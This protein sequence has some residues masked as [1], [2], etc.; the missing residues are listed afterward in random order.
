MS[1][2]RAHPRRTIFRGGGATTTPRSLWRSVYAVR[3]TLRAS[4]ALYGGGRV[5]FCLASARVPPARR[6]GSR[7]SKSLPATSTAVVRVPPLTRAPHAGVCA[8]S[9]RRRSGG[10]VW[11]AYSRPLRPRSVSSGL[12]LATV[13]AAAS[14]VPCA[15]CGV[16]QRGT[17]AAQRCMYV[18]SMRQRR[19]RRRA[20]RGYTPRDDTGG[21]HYGRHATDAAPARAQSRGLRVSRSCVV[22]RVCRSVSRRVC[23]SVHRWSCPP[24]SLPAQD[25]ELRSLRGPAACG[26]RRSPYAVGGDWSGADSAS[27]CLV[28]QCCGRCVFRPVRGGAVTGWR[29][30]HRIAQRM[31]YNSAIPADRT[32]RHVPSGSVAPYDTRR[33]ERTAHT[34]RAD[35]GGP[36]RTTWANQTERHALTGADHMT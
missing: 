13:A 35:R 15:R 9:Y 31:A 34:K 26:M 33:P 1:R 8:C 23:M 29:A 19:C 36:H 32:A 24:P 22:G 12:R 14:A 25:G 4:D 27:A 10:C 7:R 11:F 21:A 2:L 5:R 3:Q 28:Q 20:R 18:G 30:V 6:Q 17:C 16:R